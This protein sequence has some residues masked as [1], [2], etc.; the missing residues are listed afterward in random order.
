MKTNLNDLKS[1]KSIYYI[2]Q[3]DKSIYGFTDESKYLIIVKDQSLEEIKNKYCEDSKFLTFISISTWLKMAENSDLLVWK[4]SC[5]NKKYVHKEYVKLVLNANAKNLR[6]QI[7]SEYEN[8]KAKGFSNEFFNLVIDTIFVEQIIEFHKIINFK[9][10]SKYYNKFLQLS[11]IEEFDEFFEPIVS[12]LKTQTD[13]ILKKDKMDRIIK[14]IEARDKE[15]EIEK[16]NESEIQN[17]EN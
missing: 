8:L 2:Y 15:K 1:D 14:I 10:P 3:I 17:N 9:T 11:N 7:D 5:L 13:G 4:C 16:E 6:N 12:Q